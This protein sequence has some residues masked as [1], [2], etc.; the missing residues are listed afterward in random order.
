[1]S[2]SS[3]STSPIMLH[4]R[5]SCYQPPPLQTHFRLETS[6]P[7]S[8]S[9]VDFRLDSLPSISLGGGVC[10]DGGSHFS[11]DTQEPLRLETLLPQAGQLQTADY[12]L[13]PNTGN[14][15]SS[16]VQSG[17]VSLPCTG[18]PVPPPKPNLK[19]R[20]KPAL[21]PKPNL[22]LNKER[23][24]DKETYDDQKNNNLKTGQSWSGPATA[25]AASTHGRDF[26][27]RIQLKNEPKFT[28]K[29]GGKVENASGAGGGSGGVV[30]IVAQQPHSLPPPST[31]SLPVTSPFSS[32]SPSP[33]TPSPPTL[34]PPIAYTSPF[35]SSSDKEGE[36]KKC[37]LS[38][39][40]VRKQSRRKDSGISLTDISELGESPPSIDY[41]Q[42]LPS[43]YHQTDKSSSKQDDTKETG[44]DCGGSRRKDSGVCLISPPSSPD[45]SPPPLPSL[46]PPP[47]HE[48]PPPPLPDLPPPP[49]PSSLPPT[50]L[51][52]PPPDYED[53]KFELSTGEA[54]EKDMQRPALDSSRN[55]SGC[56][57][58]KGRC[59]SV[60]DLSNSAA[61]W[62]I[63]D[64]SSGRSTPAGNSHRSRIP[65]RIAAASGFLSR[66]STPAGSD[67][68]PPGRRC[69]T[70]GGETAAAKSWSAINNGGSGG[71][72]ERRSSTPSYNNS[73]ES[74]RRCSTPMGLS[75]RRS[76]DME[77]TFHN[78]HRRGPRS[79]SSLEVN[80]LQL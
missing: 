2:T 51:P 52:L 38:R 14:S 32:S 41:Y 35:P 47:L 13:R 56:A 76:S 49:L 42:G 50:I 70:P 74:S 75:G 26:T 62:S 72:W 40:P 5:Q 78:H 48:L 43:G 17:P 63:P 28:S 15:H 8:G 4:P 68:P 24:A 80:Y 30:E 46:P 6:T 25:A 27:T 37:H 16:C 57:P 22:S 77:D 55:G 34:S 79:A 3:S 19:L 58:V 7:V 73:R 66:C 23:M 36:Q 31:T 39:I 44:G 29:I 20:I 67:F 65:V 10:G 59:Q 69:S 71:L 18:K 60:S 53:S 54:E 21:Q 64:L 45:Q 61:F 1:M 33:S 12:S 11:L 9:L